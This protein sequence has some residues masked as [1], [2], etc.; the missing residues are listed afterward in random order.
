MMLLLNAFIAG[1]IFGLGLAI[2]EMINPARVIGFLDVA[3]SWD[4]T[5]AFVMAGALAVSVPLFPLILKRRR[6]LLCGEFY[7]PARRK[8][9]RPLLAGAALFGVGWGLG[10]FCPGPAL[11]GLVSGISGVYFFVIA[12]IAG[13]WLAGRVTGGQ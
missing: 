11:A 3:G 12:M 2:S 1:T 13:Q 7:L 10:G 8:I 5:L 6:P 9:D 4:P